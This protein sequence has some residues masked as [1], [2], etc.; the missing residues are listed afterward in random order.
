R[1]LGSYAGLN[2]RPFTPVTPQLDLRLPDGSRLSAVMTP[3]ERPLVSIRRN[4]YPPMFLAQAPIASTGPGRRDRPDT[5]VDPGTIDDQLAS[6]LQ[7][8]VVARCNI[9]VAG[10]TDAGKTTLLRALINCI[11]PTERLVTVERALELGLRRQG[12]HPN[13]A[14]L[15]E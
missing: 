1:T 6:F 10:A 12:L 3:C 8:A 4:R 9:M 2:A 5:L 13:V 11:P 15:E 14:E 7:A